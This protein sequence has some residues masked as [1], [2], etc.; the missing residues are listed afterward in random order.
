M[1]GTVPKRTLVAPV[2]LAP[3]IVT[4]VPPAVEPEVGD[5]DVTVGA[6]PGGGGGGGAPVHKNRSVASTGWLVPDGLVT[7]T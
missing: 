7:Y 6:G 3:L 2:K 1:A 5:R 4:E